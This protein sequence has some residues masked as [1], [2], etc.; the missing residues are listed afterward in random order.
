M[1][2]CNFANFDVMKVKKSPMF[3]IFWHLCNQISAP[4]HLFISL[5]GY[6]S[7]RIGKMNKNL[8]FT[9]SLSPSVI[10]A[11]YSYELKSSQI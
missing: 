7:K 3:S 4:D 2:N 1:K 8:S 6:R 10:G 11:D 9:D 5:A